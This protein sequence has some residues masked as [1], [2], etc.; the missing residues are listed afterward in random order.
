MQWLWCRPAAV[1][2]IRPL[3]WKFP[4]AVGVALKKSK[5]REREKRPKEVTEVQ[6]ETE[7]WGHRHRALARQT[8][9][10]KGTPNN[11]D[12]EVH[13]CAYRGRHTRKRKPSSGF[14]EANFDTNKS[15][16]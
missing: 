1:G 9:R 3:A 15:E 5:K 16:L 13:T 2:P 6:K 7:T 8:E 11:T 10:K 12:Q 4:Y 14:T